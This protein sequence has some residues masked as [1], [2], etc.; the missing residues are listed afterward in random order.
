LTD[1]TYKRTDQDN[2][3]CNKYKDAPTG[4]D[5]TKDGDVFTYQDL[6]RAWK[7][8]G[9]NMDSCPQAVITA[10]AECQPAGAGGYCSISGTAASGMW[11]VD[12]ALGTGI[13]LVN[14][15]D[16]AK[17]VI[18]QIKRPPDSSCDK[19]CYTQNDQG[20]YVANS[21]E[22]PSKALYYDTN[23][24]GSPNCNWL[25]PFC[26]YQSVQKRTGCEGVPN[27]GTCC[28]WTGGGNRGQAEGF[29]YWYEKKFLERL[30][31][32]KPEVVTE[33]IASCPGECDK[34]SEAAYK[35]AKQECDAINSQH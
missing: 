29:P 18:A 4:F 22:Q 32:V 27:P 30:K 35:Y 12:S 21:L 15:C 17:A 20:E 3:F 5:P 2:A 31:H 34:I 14:P 6:A 11:Q 26:H 19:G 23:N 1:P 28:A 13:N 7:A 25:G 9:N 16:N 33:E 8:A 10:A 24:K